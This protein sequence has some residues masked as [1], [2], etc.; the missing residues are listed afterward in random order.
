MR[1]G[2]WAFLLDIV[3]LLIPSTVAKSVVLTFTA[4]VVIAAGLVLLVDW[5]GA[6]NEFR[7]ELEARDYGIAKIIRAWPKYFWRSVGL[8][9]T[10]VGTTVLAVGVTGLVG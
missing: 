5:R 10:I 4:P 6:I 3:A 9:I 2:Q 7:G 1:V 8:G